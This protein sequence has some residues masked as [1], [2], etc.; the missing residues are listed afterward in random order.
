MESLEKILSDHEDEP[1]CFHNEI[2]EILTPV[3]NMICGYHCTKEMLDFLEKHGE[4]I[5]TYAKRC[6]KKDDEMKGHENQGR[7]F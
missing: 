4:S 6:K 1:Y 7:L 5:I 3:D 2:V